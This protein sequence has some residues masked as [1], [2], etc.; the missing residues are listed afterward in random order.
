ML[1]LYCTGVRAQKNTWFLYGTGTYDNQKY[2]PNAN[3]FYSIYNGNSGINYLYIANPF[4]LTSWAINPGLGYMVGNNLMVG[5]QGGF[6]KQENAIITSTYYYN[7]GTY[8]NAPSDYK[9][10]TTTWQAGVF[11]RYT[12]SLSKRF[13]V[14][15]QLFAGKYGS[16]DAIDRV[17]YIATPYN[18]YTVPPATHDGNG[19]VFNLSPAVGMNAFHGYGVNLSVGGLSYTTYNAI[20]ASN[21]NHFNITL[22]QFSFGIHKVIG[23]EKIT[24]APPVADK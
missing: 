4:S 16:D 13:Y 10:T 23:W 7:N 8:T 17:G 24:A 21:L 1:L 2:T 9:Q 22:G 15:T 3:S 12:S 6:G 14:Y 5:I 11:C 18:Y 19:F 20:S